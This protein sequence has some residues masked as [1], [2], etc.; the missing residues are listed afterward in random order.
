MYKPRNKK[1]STAIFEELIAM[2]RAEAEALM[3]YVFDMPY[4]FMLADAGTGE[5]YKKFDRIGIQE[6]DSRHARSTSDSNGEG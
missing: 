2:E 5:L 3:R 4:A 6:S 1:E